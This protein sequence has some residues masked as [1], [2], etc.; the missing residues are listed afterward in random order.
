MPVLQRFRL[1]R[2]RLTLRLLVLLTGGLIAMSLLQAWH[3]E[4]VLE[5]AILAQTKQ[6]AL[7]FLQG[8]ERQ[9]RNL[10]NPQSHPDLQRILH[11]AV[12][13]NHSRSFVVRSAYLYGRDGSILAHE[14][15]GHFPAKP[16]TGRYSFVLREGRPVVGDQVEFVQLA[17]GTSVPKVDIIEPVSVGGEIIAGLEAELD[18]GRTLMLVRARDNAFEK[19][20]IVMVSAAAL[21]L[22][23]F[24]GVL[25]YQG[26]VK[27]VRRIGATTG[28]IADGDF[29]ARIE[30]RHDDEL[31]TLGNAIDRMAD[32]LQRLFDEQ[33]EAY[34]SS[35]QALAKALEAKDAYTATHSGR[36][37]HFSALLGRRIGL[38]EE[39]LRLL[40]QGALM[41]DLGKI[42]IPDAILNKPSALTD[43]E[44][45]AMR[46]H[47]EYT[48]SIMRPLK[49]FRAFADIARWHHERWDG[50]GYP[51]G[52]RGEDI[53]LMAR[54]VAIADAWDAMTGDRVYRKGM[55]QQKA[56][57]I[58]ES[59][60]DLGQWDPQLV[61]QFAVLIRDELRARE[62]VQHDQS[63]DRTYSGSGQ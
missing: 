46:S 59:E 13:D 28:R 47:P 3:A 62:I 22:L 53:P 11:D 51:D 7:I 41:H 50:G 57:S 31:G 5:D 23:V 17:D 33:E 30:P 44:F 29:S 6:Q 45:E 14:P 18:V 34:M 49:R 10:D 4:K 48:Y 27:P 2:F 20:L 40:K 54:I 9:I 25:V 19:D 55:P 36:V 32:N 43:K 52:L 1:T 37:A 39:D 35:L 26:L 42:G 38:S 56:L 24:V 8:I 16:L 21:L 63:A 60:R 58:I 61:D 12:T 15:P